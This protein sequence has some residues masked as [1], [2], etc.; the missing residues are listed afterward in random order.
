MNSAGTDWDQIRKAICSG[1]FHNAAKIKGIGEY[2]NLRTGIPCV[3]HPS[4][5]IYGL[6]F[7]PDY[8][9]YHELVMT[10]KEYMQCVTA[11]DPHWLAEMG[12]MFFSVKEAYGQTSTLQRREIERQGKSKMEREMEA[13]IQ[14]RKTEQLNNPL[15]AGIIRPATGLR[16]GAGGGL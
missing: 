3:L 12:P 1:Y 11:V 10:T 8:V 7:T 9:V 4:S 6:G 16:F 2:V 14:R 15:T 5:A 13:E